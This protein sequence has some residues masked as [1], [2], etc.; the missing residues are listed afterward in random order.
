M[1]FEALLA[2]QFQHDHETKQFENLTRLL[3][4]KFGGRDD[5]HL[6][7]GNFMCNREELDAVFV[8]R[9]AFCVLEMKAV[10]GNVRFTENG[11]WYCGGREIRGGRHTN[12]FRQAKTYR[13][14]VIRKLEEWQSEGALQPAAASP[15]SHVSAAVL[16]DQFDQLDGRIPPGINSWFHIADLDRAADCLDS[17]SSPRIDFNRYDFNLI[18]ERFGGATAEAIDPVPNDRVRFIYD[19]SSELPDMLRTLRRTGGGSLRAVAKFEEAAKEANAGGSPFEQWEALQVDSIDGGTRYQIIENHSIVAISNKSFLIPVAIGRDEDI[20]AWIERN[21]GARYVIDLNGRVSSTYVGGKGDDRVS[22]TE[23]NL[24]LLSRIEIDL[25][26]LVPQ[27]VVRNLLLTILETTS[28]S[29]IEELLEAVHDENV[30]GLLSDLIHRITSGDLDGAKARLDLWN[31]DAVE[32]GEVASPRAEILPEKNSDNFVDLEALDPEELEKLFDPEKFAEW[33]IFL[34]PEQRRIAHADFKN[35]ALL[36]GVSGSGKTCVL[37]HRARHLARKYPEEQIGI[38]TLNRSLSRLIDNLVTQLCGENERKNI[39][40]FAFYDYFQQL[41]NHFGPEK[42]LENLRQLAKKDTE[43]GPEII[44]TLDQVDPLTY[45]R[46]FDPRSGETLE[47]AWKLFLEQPVV[48]TKL[49][50]YSKKMH[51]QD[52]MIDHIAYLKEEFSLIRS[53]CI[54]ESRSDEYLGMKRAGR[55][56]QLQPKY[57]K[58]VLE[59]L[60][61]FEETMISGGLIDELGLTLTV[62]PHLKTL[63]E[64]DLSL[65]GLTELSDAAAESFSKHSGPLYLDGLASLSDNAADSLSKHNGYLSFGGLT[66]LSD[67]AAKSLSTHTGDIYL[68]PSADL[69][70]TANKSLLTKSG[71]V[72]RDDKSPTR[73]EVHEKTAQSEEKQQDITGVIDVEVAKQ[74]KEGFF[75][76]DLSKF[77]KIEDKAAEEL[78]KHEGKIFLNG[79]TK[80][81]DDAAECLSKHVG[82]LHLNSLTKLSDAAAES[83]LKHTGELRL[84]GLTEV[85]DATAKLLSKQEGALHLNGLSELSDTAAELLS[86]HVGELCL[87]SLTKLSDAAAESLSKH[88]SCL[89]LPEEL[90]F[91]CLLID[92][93]QDLS[94]GDLHVLQRTVPQEDNALFLTGDMVQQVMVKTLSLPRAGFLAGSYDRE[95]I[96]KNYRNSRNILLAANELIVL[97]GQ[98][99]KHQNEEL[100]ILDPEFAIRETAWPR[101]VEAEDEIDAAWKWAADCLSVGESAPWSVCIVTTCPS[102]YSVEDILE[103]RP[104]DFSVNAEKLTGD[105]AASR[106]TMT[107]A[108]M[109]NVKGFEFSVMIIVGC[110]QACLPNPGRTSEEAWRDALRLYVAMTRARDQVILIYSGEASKVL[111]A[112]NQY[113]EWDEMETIDINN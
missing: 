57:R 103:K 36:T 3:E 80:L 73:S 91:R 54:T 65:S 97:Y 92:E 46:D 82:E 95:H 8:K 113:I 110:G 41:V 5:D 43:S 12:P 53:G 42:E 67:A 86:K 49:T 89:P 51:D 59:M 34:H 47:D 68:N 18:R 14:E 13:F 52:Q 88:K 84:T 69:S 105:Y 30:R 9:N 61:L 60:L 11:P 16:F 39:R 99:A 77:N 20:D 27:A 100:E 33:M 111:T 17:L 48:A 37:V 21:E 87:D 94:N 101:A 29:A 56:I 96:V 31:G 71:V 104:A 78:S 58:L 50:T 62:S 6:L 35:R 2:E 76:H 75:P 98:E 90:R 102:A 28:D 64:E 106:D 40:V 4:R 70:D 10:G 44:R 66:E 26:T 25:P 38:L 23:E 1:A 72:H 24:P 108:T 45:A 93:F 109:S 74:F 85:S 63:Q 107:V 81:S 83:L 19:R 22:I 15:W 32:I 79:L 55:A 112:M 7:I